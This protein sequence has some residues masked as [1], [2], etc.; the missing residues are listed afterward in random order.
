MSDVRIPQNRDVPLGQVFFGDTVRQGA[1][2]PNFHPAR[3]D[4]DGNASGCGAVIAVGQ[5]VD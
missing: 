1:G 4:V 2:V 5:G 3:K